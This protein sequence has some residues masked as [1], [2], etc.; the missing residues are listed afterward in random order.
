MLQYGCEQCV[1]PYVW[2][3]AT[4]N[5]KVCVTRDAMTRATTENTNASYPIQETCPSPLVWREATPDDHRCVPVDIRTLVSQ[6]NAAAAGRTVVS[7][8]KQP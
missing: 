3:G 1:A 5:D 4:S 7:T 2:R 8:G 6:E